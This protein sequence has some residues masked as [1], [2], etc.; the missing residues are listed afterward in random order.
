MRAF[1]SSLFVQREVGQSS[2]QRQKEGDTEG[3][4]HRDTKKRHSQGDRLAETTHT[5]T[6]SL[7]LSLPPP[8]SSTF[9]SSASHRQ[10]EHLRL[11][12]EHLRE[13]EAKL[14]E[15]SKERTAEFLDA[16][17]TL[18]GERDAVR[19]NIADL[20]RQLKDLRVKEDRL[21]RSIAKEDEHIALAEKDLE[22]EKAAVDEERSRVRGESERLGEQEAQLR[23]AK[24]ELEQST[25]S[26]RQQVEQL[27]EAVLE[28]Q[29]KAEE[30]R[31][32]LALLER[33]AAKVRVCV[34]VY[35]CMRVCS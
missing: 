31:R 6:L 1:N 26:A 18:V 10:R 32:S 35:A 25:N 4:G 16:K 33:Q 34:C 27:D 13:E 2:R 8:P 23:A 21:S 7:C 20:E 29:S 14:S 28:V 11:D 15:R 30:A 9:L 24:E 22:A 5:H 3:Q 19:R 17:R 12:Q